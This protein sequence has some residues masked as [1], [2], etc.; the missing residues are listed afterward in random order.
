MIYIYL[1]FKIKL[2]NN[3]KRQ[4]FGEGKKINLGRF[5]FDTFFRMFHFSMINADCI[6]EINYSQW[7]ILTSLESFIEMLYHF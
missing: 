1:S 2:L 6:D 3:V 7:Q 4:D 5:K